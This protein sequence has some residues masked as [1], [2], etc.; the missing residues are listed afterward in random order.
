LAGGPAG[1]LRRDRQA[2]G[3]LTRWARAAGDAPAI[4]N[5]VTLLGQERLA[6]GDFD[7]AARHFEEA[8]EIARCGD[9][10]WLLAT[11]CLNAAV[12]AL[13]VGDLERARGLLVEAEALYREMGDDRFVARAWLQLGYLALLGGDTARAGELVASALST[14][15]ELGDRWGVAEQ[16]D[17]MAAVLAARGAWRG[18]AVTAGAARPSGGALARSRTRP[19]ER[20]RVD[21]WRPC[22]RAPVPPALPPLRRAIPWRSRMPWPT[23]SQRQRQAEKVL[24]KRNGHLLLDPRTR[25]S[26]RLSFLGL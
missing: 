23:R 11:S 2:A 20:R 12:A 13:H 3:E 26:R 17:G 15:S 19:T 22:F 6:A 7:G 10:V 9:S 25:C 21:G 5:G 8:L 24:W 18:A 1:R 4:R 16:L 14:T